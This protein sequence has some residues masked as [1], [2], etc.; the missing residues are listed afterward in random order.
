MT[1]VARLRGKLLQ[2]LDFLARSAAAYDH[3]Y[4]DEAIRMA[5]HMRVLFSHSR[6]SAGLVFQLGGKKI[7]LNSTCPRFPVQPLQFSGIVDFVFRQGQT[8]GETV[9]PLDGSYTIE[10]HHFICSQIALF[11]TPKPPPPESENSRHVNHRTVHQWLN[12]LIFIFN[13]KQRLTRQDL[14][15]RAANQDGAAHVDLTLDPDYERLQRPGGIP[16]SFSWSQGGQQLSVKDVH[17]PALRQMTYELL[18]SPALRA[19]AG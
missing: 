5:G 15:E 4:K 14:L 13:P 8:E 11:P 17:L 19:L 9:A 12:E 1:N 6:K 2:Q 10:G 16:L 18:T 7:L 3:G